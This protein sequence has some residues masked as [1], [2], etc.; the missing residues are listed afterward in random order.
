LK[1]EAA[2]QRGSIVLLEDLGEKLDPNI[3][4]LLSK[5]TFFEDGFEKIILGENPIPYDNNFK[6]FMTTK[7]S[8]PHF[9]AETSIKL[10][11]INFTVTLP[12][13][14]QQLLADVIKNEAPDIEIQRD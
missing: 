2:V 1:L 6:L 3:E 7:L 5:S 12:G 9:S 8:N 4:N 11:I 14:E 13:L 10:A